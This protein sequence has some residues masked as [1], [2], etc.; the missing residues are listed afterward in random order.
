MAENNNPLFTQ[1]A[2]IG[3]A[4]I[5]DA[6]TNRDGTGSIETVVTGSANGTRINKI[7]IQAIVTTTAGIIRLYIFDGV[8]TTVLWKEVEVSAITVSGTVIGFNSIISLVGE[9]ALVLPNGYELKVSTHN[10][11]AFKV[12][13]HGGNY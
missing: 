13:A 1:V 7:V 6:N 10:A 2:V 11:E 4:E 3:I 9:L 5:S 8:E 12:F